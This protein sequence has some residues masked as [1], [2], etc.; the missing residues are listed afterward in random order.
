MKALSKH[1]FTPL[2][3]RRVHGSTFK[4]LK[5]LEHTQWWPR[6][7]LVALQ[8]VRLVGLISAAY[9]NTA[10]YRK[11]LAERGLVPQNISTMDDL[12]KLPVLTRAAVRDNFHAL[13]AENLKPGRMK[14][15]E[16]G[17]TTGE[18][19]RF[20][21][22][23]DEG[24]GWG[25]YYR[26]LEWY[27]LS[28]GD[29]H[30]LI[31]GYSPAASRVASF[32][33]GTGHF[34]RN[35]AFLNAFDLSEARM[36][37]FASKLKKFQPKAI[38][39]YS[40]AVYIFAEYVKQSQIQ[41]IRPGLAITTAEKLYD[42]QRQAIKEAFEC[43]VFQYYGSREVAS[44]GYECPQH[45]GY[46]T[47]ME[48]V[49][50]ETVDERGNR[51]KPGEVGR[52]LVTDLHN[53][54]MPLIRYELGDLGILSDE[55]CP[56]GRGL[57]VIASIEGRMTDVIVCSRGFISPVALTTYVFKDMPVRQFQVVQETLDDVRVK[58]VPGEGFGREETG[59]IKE[60]LQARM[61]MGTHVG[62]ELVDD[63][64]PSPSSGKRRVVISKVPSQHNGL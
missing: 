31:W 46:H 61:G 64:P 12:A 49:V 13:I 53:Y 23:G 1:I 33:A 4:R 8:N 50:L 7:K 45:H 52:V 47:S 54:A 10:Y 58:V 32:L 5:E 16:T 51:V 56:C 29:K 44:L 35:C 24:W 14:L 2:L 38:A 34:L 60:A 3:E 22:P 18:P 9:Q 6:E 19:L 26:G 48:N 36:A 62:V 28:S 21:K 42:Y 37:A 39:G 17:G 43:D 57:S 63:I 25:A 11:A 15:G 41:G 30:S 27:G 55:A 59:R 20:M 40:S